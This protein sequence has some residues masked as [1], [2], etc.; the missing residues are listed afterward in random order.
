MTESAA[1]PRV[2]F[3][4][5]AIALCTVIVFAKFAVHR[6]GERREW[7]GSELSHQ[8]CVL[9]AW[10]AIVLSLLALAISE[11]TK[12]D[13]SWMRWTVFGAAVASS[14]I[15]A[16]DM[17]RNT[18]PR[19]ALPRASASVSTLSRT[20]AE[21]GKRTQRAAHAIAA[22]HE[23]LQQ[24]ERAGEFAWECAQATLEAVH[25]GLSDNDPAAQEELRDAATRLRRS[26]AVAIEI[27][28]QTPA[29]SPRPTDPEGLALA[30]SAEAET[31]VDR[32]DGR[33]ATD[34]PDA[35]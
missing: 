28:A 23:P 20:A 5:G 15:L 3:Y 31:I 22:A 30:I 29:S 10:I 11:S 18:T 34:G 6:Y 7:W 26:A 9:S 17:F 21:A 16:I 14:I 27:V 2:D 4:A 33:R 8:A 25:R 35:S 24:L 1:D 12:D 32:L 13:R 19:R